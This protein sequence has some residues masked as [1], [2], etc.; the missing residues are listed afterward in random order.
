VC[1]FGDHIERDGLEALSAAGDF[2][3]LVAEDRTEPASDLLGL[4][5]LVTVCLCGEESLLDQVF[6][7]GR[8][9]GQSSC[10]SEEQASVLFDQFFEIQ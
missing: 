5:K 1:D 3:E 9:A 7:I 10:E 8:A 6:G 4:P 2:E